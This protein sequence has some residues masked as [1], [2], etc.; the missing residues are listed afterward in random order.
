MVN[1]VISIG[2]NCGD[3]YKNVE[4][5]LEWL[6]SIL[7]EVQCSEIY[8]TPCALKSGSPY[9]NAVLKGVYQGLGYDLEERLKEKEHQMG[10]N[11]E[12]RKRGEVPVD[13]DIVVMDGEVV[14]E[15]DFRQK[16][17]QIGY[18]QIS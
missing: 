6:K 15:W 7:I 18:I 12:C 10:R 14:K 17:F 8:E 13:I 4:T 2:S 9:V 11:V 16:F 3:R 1:V 5:A